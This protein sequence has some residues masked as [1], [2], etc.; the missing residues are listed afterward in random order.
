MTEALF[1]SSSVV[2]NLQSLLLHIFNVALIV[3]FGQFSQIGYRLSILVAFFWGLNERHHE[4]V[5]WYASIPEQLVLFFM[6]IAFGALLK[7]WEE[8]KPAYYAA[9]MGAFVLALMSK[10][11]GVVFCALFGVLMIYHRQRWRRV[12]RAA[13]P[14]FAL[15]VIYFAF[16]LKSRE[17]HLHWNDG[18]FEFGWHF[19]PVIANSAA[20]LF[21]LW[22][23]AAVAVLVYFR[24]SIDWRGPLLAFVWIP[25]ALAPYSFVVYQPRVPSRHVYMASIGIALILAFALAKLL[26]MRIATNAILA[27]YLIFNTGY[28]WFYKHGQF[29]ERAEVTERMIGDAKALVSQYGTRPIRVL[30]FPL[31][32][33]IASIALNER[34]GID[35]GLVSVVRAFDS[36][37]GKPKV[38]LVQD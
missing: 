1:G 4:A 10:E 21:T 9:S 3:S 22:G 29:V 7:W 19:V 27:A 23:L 37:C 6:L 17:N 32:P 26:P 34:L 30:C 18:T 16:N 20:R 31:A 28:I 11:S 12:A 35:P 24:K 13:I 14:F 38:E 25:V 36:S 33:E 2:L 5:M 8:G 15:S